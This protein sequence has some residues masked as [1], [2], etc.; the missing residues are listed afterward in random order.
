MN[1]F[2]IY[3]LI[4]PLL[5]SYL[6]NTKDKLHKSLSKQNLQNVFLVKTSYHIHINIWGE[7][8]S[9]FLVK[10]N[11]RECTDHNMAV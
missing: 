7:E 9:V 5:C 2:K 8:Q 1:Q 10:T 11:M 4:V 3:F 6:N